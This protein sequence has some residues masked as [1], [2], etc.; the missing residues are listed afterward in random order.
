MI[1]FRAAVRKTG[2][3]LLWPDL[4]YIKIY[5]NVGFYIAFSA[6]TWYNPYQSENA[7]LIERRNCAC[8]LSMTGM[9]QNSI[10][11]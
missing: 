10:P 3:G 5:K 4:R 9:L 1:K 7:R 11:T 6:G 2:R 8:F